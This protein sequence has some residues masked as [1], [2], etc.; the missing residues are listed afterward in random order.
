[1]RAF[2]T[3]PVWVIFL[4]SVLGVFLSQLSESTLINQLLVIGGL[5]MYL[6]YPFSVA[7]YLQD[8][9]PKKIVLN[10]GL[11]MFNV[12]FFIGLRIFSSIILEGGQWKAT[13]FSA[14]PFFYAFYAM[15]HVLAFPA[16]TIKT[17]ELGK[18][19]S[20][21]DYLGDFFLILFL[22]IGIWFLQPRVKKIIESNA[23]IK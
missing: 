4:V 22:P 6:L 17:I 2:L 8:Y 23:G 15:L 13:G 12:F 14:I 3:L 10:V 11:F 7:I 18:K 21:G 20:L 16:K 9:L 1:M 19:A 5:G